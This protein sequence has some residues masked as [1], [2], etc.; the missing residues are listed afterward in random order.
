MK[1]MKDMFINSIIKGFGKTIGS[2]TVIV[3]VTIIYKILDTINEKV[4]T[5]IIIQTE[6]EQEEQ[7]E[8]INEHEI[9]NYGLNVCN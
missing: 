8:D 3:S 4:K 1:D 9:V 7:E 6:E 2:L 5:D